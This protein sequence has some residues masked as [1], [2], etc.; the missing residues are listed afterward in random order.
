[1]TGNDRARMSATLRS[2][3]HADAE[4]IAEI[5]LQARAAFLPYAPFAHT[6]DQVRGW[7]RDTLLS[8]EDVTIACVNGRVVGVLAMHRPNGITWI[9]QLYLDPA[10]VAQ[11]IGTCL[12]KRALA[13]AARPVRLYTFQ[14]N[15]GARRF[16]ERNGFVAV[17]FTDGSD[18]EERCPDVFY[19]LAR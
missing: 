9:S 2:A 8:S 16:Y 6:D 3:E 19:E 10:Y 12:L 18:N 5:L 13:T 7:V 17:H 11:G 4:R 15:S 14:Q 1:M